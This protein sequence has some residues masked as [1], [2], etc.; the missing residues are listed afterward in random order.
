MDEIADE[1]GLQRPNLYRYFP[2]RDA[3]IG[4]VIVRE[5]GITNAQRRERISL[6]G[7]IGPILVES[8]VLGN[9]I[10]RSDELTQLLLVSDMRDTTSA[11]ATSERLIMRAESEY[12]NP[13]LSYG[14]SRG[15][16]NP[17]MSDDRIVRWFL[18][19][20]VLLSTRAETLSGLAD[21]MRGFFVDFI[22]PPVLVAGGWTPQSAIP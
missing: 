20:Q 16:V 6:R 2:S 9:E 1:A 21:D 8:L 5:I 19:A 17:A 3:L 12:W 4:A 22:V 15:E 10:A 11:I 13:V 14:R 18:A 7:P